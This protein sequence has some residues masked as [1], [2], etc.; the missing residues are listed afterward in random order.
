[1]HGIKETLFDSDHYVCVYINPPQSS[2]IHLLPRHLPL[3][4]STLSP[5]L[6][7]QFDAPYGVSADL[8][9]DFKG[10]VHFLWVYVF[11]FSKTPKYCFWKSLNMNQDATNCGL[12]PTTMIM[13]PLRLNVEVIHIL[14]RP[15]K[16]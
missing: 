13:V 15:F 5:S 4:L 12:Y 7:I 11:H 10:I 6:S 16:T 1:M 14:Y 2:S 3:L 9:L 8:T